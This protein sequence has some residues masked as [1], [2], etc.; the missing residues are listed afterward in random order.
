MRVRFLKNRLVGLLN[1]HLIDYP[2]PLNLSYLWGF[3]SLSGLCLGIQLLTGIFLGMHYCGNV[4]MAFESVEHIMR[5]VSNGWLIRY[6]HSN[7]ASMFFI[8]VYIHM[9]RG[10]YYGSYTYPR[11]KLWVSGVLIFLLMILTA[12]IGYVLPWGQM[13]LWGATVITNLVSTIPLIGKNVVHWLWGGFAV[14]NATLNRFYSLHY[15]M[16]FV[17]SGLAILHIILLHVDGS[18]NRLGVDTKV[19]KVGFYP[20]CYVKDLLV[21]LLMLTVFSVL[22]HFTPN[23]LGHSDNYILANNLVTPAH[24]VPEWYFLTFYAILRSV[25]HKLGG[26]ILMVAAIVV[27]CLLPLLNGA[28]VRSNLFKPLTRKLFWFFLI[29]CL[30]LGWL[31]QKPVESPFIGLGQVTSLVYFSVLLIGLPLLGRF[32]MGMFRGTSDTEKVQD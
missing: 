28:E 8:M 9:F 19:S 15:L 24:I 11:T 25:P 10:L 18:S 32:E 26:V 22:V 2:T 16:P 7:G 1:N 13:S 14:E 12:F 3:G 21:F 4:E 5:D 6:F 23:L 31:G 29:D 20:Y 27:L 17:I 30:I